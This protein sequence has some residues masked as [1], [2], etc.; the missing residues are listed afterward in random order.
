[1]LITA[2]L[3]PVIGQTGSDIEDTKVKSFTLTKEQLIND[4][5]QLLSYIENIHPDPYMYSG[6][7]WNSNSTLTQTSGMH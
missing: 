5:R 4:S 6:A 1:M 3:Q 7:K 2:N